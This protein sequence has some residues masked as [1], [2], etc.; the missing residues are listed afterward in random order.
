MA[1][2]RAQHLLSLLPQAISFGAAELEPDVEPLKV[3][4]LDVVLTEILANLVGRI[5]IPIVS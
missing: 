1:T 2:H 4:W 5:M 3:C